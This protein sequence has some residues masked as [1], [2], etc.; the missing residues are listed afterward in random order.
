MFR[1]IQ[2]ETIGTMVAVVVLMSAAA[3][4]GP[5]RTTTLTVDPGAAPTGRAVV[6]NRLDVAGDAVEDPAT[7]LFW[8]MPVNL[9]QAGATLI[10]E[11]ARVPD[12]VARAIAVTARSGGS[13]ARIDAIRGVGPRTME[14]L[15]SSFV[16]ADPL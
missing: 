11:H 16:L 5:L 13:W 6:Y 2:P 7:R 14:R 15:Q 1:R 12:T 8:G 4:A 9:G 10:A 3:P